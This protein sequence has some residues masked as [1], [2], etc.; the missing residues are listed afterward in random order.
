MSFISSLSGKSI[1]VFGAGVTG[2]PTIEF[3]RSKDAK[4]ILIDEKLTGTGIF[5]DL[6]KLDLSSVDFAVVSPGWK[7]DN[8][9][10][11]ELKKAGISIISEIDLAWRVKQELKPQ[12]K[13][14]ALTGTNGKTTAVQMTEAM[15]V[16][17]G[18]NAIACGNIGLTA[19][20]AVVNTDAE[21]L[22]LELSSFQLEWSAEAKF[23]SVAILNIAEDHIDWHGSFDNYAK[24]K[25]KITNNAEYLILNALDSAI[26]QRA[27]NLT[28]PIIWFSLETPKP[29]QIG[30]VENLIVD[31]A[32]VSDEAE[33]LFE[34]SDINP[35]V[36]HNVLNAMA[37]AGLARSVGSKAESIAQALRSFKLDHHR[38]EV[39]AERD[40]VIWIDDSK[41]TNPHAAMAALNSQMKSI[42]IAGGLAKGATMD[43]LV[44]NCSSRIKAA[45]LIGSDAPIIAKA[46]EDGAPE[47]PIHQI[48][49]YSNSLDL[50]KKVVGLA[51]E[52]AQSGDTVLLAPACASMDQ[53]KNYAER[54]Q[55]FSEAVKG[56][57]NE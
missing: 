14:L 27:K 29:H 34:L 38:L 42:W 41:A 15:L 43:E 56:Y 23:I 46:L 57:L 16:A 39:V 26:V 36:P 30:L 21:F 51:K 24:A 28:H 37:A 2:A 32:F 20:E 8:P 40:G 35:A 11:L 6:S 9:L 52:L 49:E 31:R 18:H 44:K 13:W 17:D 12:Q 55:L 22:I 48:K 19:I 1:V 7:V 45:I 53:F 25:F 5:N 33:A 50:M 47:I 4:T 3:L 54:G 10:I